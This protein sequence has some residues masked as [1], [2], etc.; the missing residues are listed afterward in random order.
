MSLVR[1]TKERPTE[2]SLK[3]RFFCAAGSILFSGN[4]QISTVH[5][6]KNIAAMTYANAMF[7]AQMNPP[8]A[9]PITDAVSKKLAF[10]AAALGK[11]GAGTSCGISAARAG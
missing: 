7:F 6:A 2:R 10:Q 4:F 11:I 8:I 9:G 5:A 1:Q 3:P